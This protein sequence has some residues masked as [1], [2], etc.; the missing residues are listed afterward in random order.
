MT[1]AKQ[2]NTIEKTPLLIFIATFAVGLLILFF[3]I[4][5]QSIIPEI[6]LDEPYPSNGGG[7]CNSDSDCPH[8][9]V[10]Y[11]SGSGMRCHDPQFD[12]DCNSPEPSHQNNPS[13]S[14]SNE[15]SPSPSDEPSPPPPAYEC[16][17]LGPQPDNPQRGDTVA[18]TC[19]STVT[20][21][22]INHYNFRV[23]GT[24]SQ[25]VDTD[26]S[27]ATYNFTVP[28]TETE[29]NVQCQV[30][31]STDDSNCTQWGQSQ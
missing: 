9:H 23:N 5:S 6:F 8:G 3:S 16:T 27:Q 24:S 10:C 26:A 4:T 19:T 21:T 7:E 25:R 2:K 15:P 11:N 22:T 17:G 13:P 30:C 20:D 28:E 29:F 14:P 31:T 18:F 12:P 1:T